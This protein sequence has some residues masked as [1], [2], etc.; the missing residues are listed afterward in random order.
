MARLSGNSQM[1]GQVKVRCITKKVP[2]SAKLYNNLKKKVKLIK[3][4]IEA[5]S[6]TCDHRPP[7]LSPSFLPD[8]GKVVFCSKCSKTVLHFSQ[9]CNSIGMRFPL[10]F[11]A[12]QFSSEQYFSCCAVEE[13]VLAL[14]LHIQSLVVG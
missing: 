14:F 10:T 1:V 3:S 12:R 8:L 6:D 5:H 7:L 11:T 4:D 13:D 9:Y 2:A